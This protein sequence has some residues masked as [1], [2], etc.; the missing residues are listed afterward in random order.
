MK[1]STQLN[2]QEA[3]TEVMFRLERLE[4]SASPK[5]VMGMHSNYR[6]S[7]TAAHSGNRERIQMKILLLNLH[8]GVL[9]GSE[10]LS[11]E[12]SIAEASSTC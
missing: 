5:F 12:A 11:L 7:Y 1:P 9:F 8:P 3:L 10:I 4:G 2:T 6:R